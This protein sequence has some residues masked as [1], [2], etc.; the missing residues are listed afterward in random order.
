VLLQERLVK[1]ALRATDP[2]LYLVEEWSSLN[3][4][5]YAVKISIGEDLEPFTPIH[6]VHDGKPL[7]LSLNL[8]D[9]LRAQEGDV[10]EA[11]SQATAS[12]IAR[13][14]RARQ[15]R[16]AVQADLI[17]EYHRWDKRGFVK[18]PDGVKWS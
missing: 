18:K 5:Y 11:I 9:E 1:R 8:I 4:P 12:N 10:T 17:D 2:D 6:W 7:P 3:F 16:M 13:K 15:E 14:E